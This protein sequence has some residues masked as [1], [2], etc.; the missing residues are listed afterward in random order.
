MA[1]RKP[2]S[3]RTR[4]RVERKGRNTK[5]PKRSLVILCEGAKT[6]PIYFEALI[7]DLGILKSDKVAIT[8]EGLGDN[9]INLVRAAIARK[10]SP[11]VT[12]PETYW[13]VMDRDIKRDNPNNK[14]NFKKALDNARENDIN[15]AYS[16]DCFEAWFLMHYDFNPSSTP[17]SKYKDMLT[18]KLGEAYEK[19]QCIFHKHLKSKLKTAIRNAKRLHK[20]CDKHPYDCDPSTTVHLL[21][22]ELQEI[23]TNSQK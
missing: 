21:V 23:A 20:E 8:I 16:I 15:I 3:R 10:G 5:S 4:N 2:D 9:T 17:R 13:V 14:N 22:Q 12:E 7:K 1:K 6:E 19:N 11:S 18:H